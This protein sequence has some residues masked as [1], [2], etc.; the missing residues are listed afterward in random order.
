MKKH[1]SHYKFPH[2][3]LEDLTLSKTDKIAL[4]EDWAADEQQKLTAA[5]ENMPLKQGQDDD[6]GEQLSEISKALDYLRSN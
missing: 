6:E 5:E 3:I 2:E 4:L 1:Y